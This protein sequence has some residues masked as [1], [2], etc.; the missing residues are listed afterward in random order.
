MKKVFLLATLIYL[1]LPLSLMPNA[2]ASQAEVNFL[3]HVA[4]QYII[5]QF[6]KRPDDDR[7]IEVRA[8]KLD[9]S[10]NYGGRCEGYL[11]AEL[12][13]EELKNSNIVKISCT[14]PKNGYTLLVPVSVKILRPALVAV[15]NIPHGTMITDEL[16]TETYLPE[17]EHQAGSVGLRSQVVGSKVKKDIKAGEQIKLN[18]FCLVCK[19]DQVNLIAEKGNLSLKAAGFALTDGNYGDAI[20]VRNAK[21]KKIV[22]AVVRSPTEVQVVF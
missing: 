8:S 16:L 9:G 5:A 3:R 19:G 6:P 21:S 10:R 22:Q 14:R 1:T 7:K 20:Q 4:E 13:G 18:S 2:A 15:Q 17:H 12:Q 11:T